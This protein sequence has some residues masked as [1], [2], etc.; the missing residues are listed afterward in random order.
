MKLKYRI[1]EYVNAVQLKIWKKLKYYSPP[2]FLKGTWHL[3]GILFAEEDRGGAYRRVF[4]SIQKSSDYCSHHD[5]F[6]VVGAFFYWGKA[7]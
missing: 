3:L 7:A 4:L 1:F 6:V 2:R 5:G